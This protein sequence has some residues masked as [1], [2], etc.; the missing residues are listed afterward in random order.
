MRIWP[1]LLLAPALALADQVIAF[2]T[3]GWACARGQP[4]VVHAEH[5]VFF[6]AAVATLPSAWHAW[7]DSRTRHAAA[8]EREAF[9]AGLAVGSAAMSAIVI[10]AM[11]LPTWLIAPC[12]R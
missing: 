8:G 6:L 12:V 10:A 1:A 3:L 7:K 4:I 9:L 5:V 11:S 2:A